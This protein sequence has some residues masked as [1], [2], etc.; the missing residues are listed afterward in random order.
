MDLQQLNTNEWTP[1][2]AW[3]MDFLK[4]ALLFGLTALGTLFGIQ[5]IEERRRRAEQRSQAWFAIDMAALDQF[6]KAAVQYEV[7]ARAAYVDLYI[8]TSAEKTDTMRSYEYAGY[9][10]YLAALG[11]VRQRFAGDLALAKLLDEYEDAQN[12]RHSVYD[13]IVDL[14]LDSIAVDGKAV[15]LRPEAAKWRQQFNTLLTA[16]ADLRVQ[17]VG[18]LEQKIL[19]KS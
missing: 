6:L 2:F 1:L 16:A 13:K 18:S 4:N 8:W 5:K 15:D 19:D 12:A 17:I 7:L 3:F 11:R 9:A 10:E 14:Q